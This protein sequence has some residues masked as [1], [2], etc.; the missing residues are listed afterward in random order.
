MENVIHRLTLDLTGADMMPRVEVQQDN[1]RSIVICLTQGGQPY[2]IAEGVTAVFS[3]RK[4]DGNPLFNACTIEKNRVRYDFTD[5]TTNVAG[6]VECEILLYDAE[7]KRLASSRFELAIDELIHRDGDVPESAPEVT[8]LT[9]MVADGTAMLED[10]QEALAGL[11]DVEEIL[12]AARKAVADAE[13]AAERAENAAGRAEDALE[14]MGKGSVDGDLRAKGLILETRQENDGETGVVLT[15]EGTADKPVVHLYGVQGDEPVTVRGV[16]PAVQDED[17]PNL[18]QVREMVRNGSGQNLNL[19]VEIVTVDG[20]P[21][22]SVAVTGLSLDLTDC[23][24]K[25]GGGFY[26]NPVVLPANATNRSV[27]WQSSKPDVAAVNGMGFV[28]CIAAG[29]AVI[30]CTTVDGGFTATCAVS[31]AAES[32]GG[33]TE[34]TLSGIS[35]TYSGGDVA[36]GTAVTDLTGIV[37]TAHYS[38]GSTAT[39]TDYTLSGTIAEGSNTVTASHSG[40]TTTF[41]V[42]GVAESDGTAGSKIQLSSLDWESGIMKA[43]GTVATLGKTYYTTVP[44]SEG[45]QISTGTNGAWNST[46]YPPIVVLDRGVYSAPAVTKTDNTITVQASAVTQYTATLTDYSLDAVVYVSA[47]TGFADPNTDSGKAKMDEADIY[48]YIPGGEA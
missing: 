34:V 45:M 27:S 24:A 18:G 5:Q 48:Y 21:G 3:G 7:G 2:W 1:A 17:V 16:A 40:K 31:V 26:I 19:T 10:L 12:T 15:P 20:D 32:S 39:V 29:E 6:I 47:L 13:D 37:V 9:Q 23:S 46:Q 11:S 36:V 25:V 30:T 28:E 14:K 22:E 43:D 38:D 41:T 33:E 42:T 35:A 44:Y 4:P 8:A